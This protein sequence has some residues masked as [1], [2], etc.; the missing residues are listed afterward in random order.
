M[1][2]TIRPSNSKHLTA[3]VRRRLL[4][5]LAS[6]APWIE[7]AEALLG[8][9]ADAIHPP[10]NCTCR[11]V[12]HLKSGESL[13]IEDDGRDWSES[14]SIVADRASRWVRRQLALHQYR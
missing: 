14:L 5:A 6:Y 3:S 4:L 8:P 7:R 1:R 11:L 10:K 2:L 9:E 13:E 12:V